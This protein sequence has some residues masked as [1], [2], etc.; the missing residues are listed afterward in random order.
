MEK[1]S[2]WQRLWNVVKPS[3]FVISLVIEAIIIVGSILADFTSLGVIARRWVLPLGIVL[4]VATLIIRG[5]MKLQEMK[6]Q[7]QAKEPKIESVNR[8]RRQRIIKAESYR[9]AGGQNIAANTVNIYGSGEE[10][11][12]ATSTSV[13]YDEVMKLMGKALRD[14]SSLLNSSFTD[15]WA[16]LS[17]RYNSADLSRTALYEHFDNY[18]YYFSANVQSSLDELNSLLHTSAAM[19]LT[20]LKSGPTGMLLLQPKQYYQRCEELRE[21]I[22]KEFQKGLE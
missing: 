7:N 6:S 17:L 5:F 8:P 20:A 2:F 18:R 1:H 19:W 9:Q 11:K 10:K 12:V 4:F 16:N 13:D 22:I 3:W 15:D 14:L 21:E